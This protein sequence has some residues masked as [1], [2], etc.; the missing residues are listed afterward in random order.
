MTL[1]NTIDKLLVTSMIR[2][3]K[4]C[5]VILI[6]SKHLFEESIFVLDFFVLKI[7]C[8]KTSH[9]LCC[10]TALATNSTP[11]GAMKFSPSL[12]EKHCPDLTIRRRAECWFVIENWEPVINDH[13]CD[14]SVHEHSDE[15]GTSAIHFLEKD[16]I[17]DPLW[18]FSAST[19]CGEEVTITEHTLVDVVGIHLVVNNF[20]LVSVNFRCTLPLKIIS[21]F[22]TNFVLHVG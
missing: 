16:P 20:E 5:E 22:F 3:S 10:V 19:H 14:N 1:C 6:E 8:W 11:V 2:S 4:D 21:R 17:S 13:W 9:M 7:F 15:I 18:L 12:L